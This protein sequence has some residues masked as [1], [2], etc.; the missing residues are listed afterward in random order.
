[1]PALPGSGRELEVLAGLFGRRAQ[2]LR[3]D[4]A[5]PEVL[6]SLLSESPAI[7]HLATHGFFLTNAASGRLTGALLLANGVGANTEARPLPGVP[8]GSVLDENL[9]A[10]LPLVGSLVT[11]S[12]CESAR[13]RLIPGEG[14]ISLMR[15]F[16]IA[17]A[18][19]VSASLWLAGDTST[20][21]YMVRYYKHIASGKRPAL[22]HRDTRR[23]LRDLGFW[24]SQRS[25]F[26]TSN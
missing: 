13:G 16:I 15:A 20:A 3:G 11:L 24:P 25:G 2:T 6:A 22:A 9:I 10:A 18:K 14:M 12:A 5:S 7:L 8:G 17:G 19:N 21:E 1:M 4:A 26:I 23:E